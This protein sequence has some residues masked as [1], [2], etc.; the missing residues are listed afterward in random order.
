M[1]I[2]TLSLPPITNYIC[3]PFFKTKTLT[4]TLTL[5]FFTFFTFLMIFLNAFQLNLNVRTLEIH[6]CETQLLLS[7]LF[8]SVF[9][10]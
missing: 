9:M 4:L 10:P 7:L 6:S 2:Y 8:L 3:I 5:T 1:K